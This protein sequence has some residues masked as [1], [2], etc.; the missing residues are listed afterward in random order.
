[1]VVKVLAD[2]LGYLQG[3]CLHLTVIAPFKQMNGVKMNP[4]Y[5]TLF[6]QDGVVF[7]NGLDSHFF[8]E[9]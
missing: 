8:V 7:I 4:L 1:M 9:C 6:L 3:I 5:F 2:L